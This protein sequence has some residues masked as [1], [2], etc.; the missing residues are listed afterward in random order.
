MIFAATSGRVRCGVVGHHNS[1]ATAQNYKWILI[2]PLN[3]FHSRGRHSAARQNHLFFASCDRN[4]AVLSPCHA[5]L[6]AHDM[7]EA[8]MKTRW[9]LMVAAACLALGAAPALAADIT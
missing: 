6:V 9:G 5:Q 3:G 1:F 4:I 8:S 2:L 7:K